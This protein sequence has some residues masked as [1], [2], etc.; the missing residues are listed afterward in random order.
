MKTVN[1]TLADGS[2]YTMTIDEFTRWMCLAEAFHFIEEKAKELQVDVEKLIKPLA[3][4]TY[5]KERFD[6]MKHDVS[7]EL[8][9]GIL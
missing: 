8:D 1:L 6:S 7:H 2:I 3:I 5:I 9:H 4:E